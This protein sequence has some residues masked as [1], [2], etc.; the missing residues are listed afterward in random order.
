MPTAKEREA[1]C[2]GGGGDDGDEKDHAD[3]KEHPSMVCFVFD[4]YRYIC[5]ISHELA[6]T[7]PTDA[8][9]NGA[10]NRFVRYN[11]P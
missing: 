9:Y 5:H 3:Q 10:N 1:V 2:L 4:H 8:F 7:Q 6:T 11:Q